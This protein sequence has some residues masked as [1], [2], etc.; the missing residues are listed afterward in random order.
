MRLLGL[1]GL[2]G[3]GKDTVAD[4]LVTLAPMDRRAFADAL[5]IEIADAFGIDVR[6]LQDRALREKPLSQLALSR[7]SDLGFVVWAKE[8]YREPSVSPRRIMRRWGDWRR[9]QRADYWLTRAEQAR[10]AAIFD[11]HQAQLWTDVRYPNEA[12][13]VRSRGGMLWRIVRPGLEQDRSHDSE[14]AAD[15]I[16]ADATILNAGSLDE[17]RMRVVD[18]A[19]ALEGAE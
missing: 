15:R 12:N 14:T 13:W 17:L 9:W 19:D 6:V 7:C 5:R 2:A 3:A 1:M 10:V 8:L 16:E 11:G 4:I 18:L